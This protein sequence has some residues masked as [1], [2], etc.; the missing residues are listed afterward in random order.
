[1]AFSIALAIAAIGCGAGLA[2]ALVPSEGLAILAV[3]FVAAQS[4]INA[5]LDIRVLFRTDM[6]INGEVVGASDAHNMATSTFGNHWLW[7]SV[8]LA[9]SCLAF[10]V[11]LRIIYLRH[12]AIEERAVRA[13]AR[14]QAQADAEA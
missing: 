12:L 6:V 7:A 4:C 2:L 5:L 13:A 11:A 8:W 3:N 10:Y 1:M 14:A 9:W